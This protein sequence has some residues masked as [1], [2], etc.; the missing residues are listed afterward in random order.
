MCEAKFPSP[1]NSSGF[2][3]AMTR[4]SGRSSAAAARAPRPASAMRSGS[5]S[6]RRP[7]RVMAAPAM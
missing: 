5:G 6:A 1:M 4:A 7:T 2:I 3:T